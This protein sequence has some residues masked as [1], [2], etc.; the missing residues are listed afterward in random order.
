ML[1]DPE[2]IFKNG[3]ELAVVITVIEINFFNPAIGLF[4]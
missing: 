1:A 2:R 3:K 4:P